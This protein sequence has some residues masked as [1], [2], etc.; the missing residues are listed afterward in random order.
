MTFDFYLGGY[1]RDSYRLTLNNGSLSCSQYYGVPTE[2]D[3]IIK[4]SNNEH[5]EKLL[6][7]LKNCSWEEVYDSTILDGTQWELKVMGRGIR[8]NSYG[9]NVYPDNFDV[10]LLLLNNILNEAE[11][12]ID[13]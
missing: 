13:G 2:H 12:H 6:S 11:I 8:I 9:S 3:K 1:G 5:W 4:I 10:F 7:F